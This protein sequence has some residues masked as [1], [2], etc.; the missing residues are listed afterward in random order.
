M[1]IHVFSYLTLRENISLIACIGSI[2]SILLTV[3]M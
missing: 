2:A 1:L 3:L